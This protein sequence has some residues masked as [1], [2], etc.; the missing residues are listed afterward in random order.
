M[1][2]LSTGFF[3]PPSECGLRVIPTFHSPAVRIS[4][5]LANTLTTKEQDTLLKGVE[6]FKMRI[7]GG[8]HLLFPF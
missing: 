8:H 6:G 5:L 1:V 2:L 4:K 7:P 3:F